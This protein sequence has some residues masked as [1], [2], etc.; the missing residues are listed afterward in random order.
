MPVMKKDEFD[1][2]LRQ[3]L[4]RYVEPVPADFTD[5]ISEQIKEAEEREILARVVMEER[6]ALAGCV[7]LG[8]MTIVAVAVFPDIVASFRELVET[9]V[10]R[11]AQA[12]ETVHYGWHLYTV[13]VGVLGVIAYGLMDLLVSDSW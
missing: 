13:F 6:F 5:R 4:Q 1:I 9:S 11:A 12:I 2:M 3:A 10:R 8:I 7:V